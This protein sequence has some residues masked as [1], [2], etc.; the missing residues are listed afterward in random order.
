MQIVNPQCAMGIHF[1]DYV[2]TQ[3]PDQLGRRGPAANTSL[4]TLSYPDRWLNHAKAPAIRI[5][6]A[7]LRR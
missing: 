1:L 5:G 6:P 7:R 2:D 3:S 4:E